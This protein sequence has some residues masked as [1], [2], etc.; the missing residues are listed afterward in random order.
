MNR[1]SVLAALVAGG[2]TLSGCTSRGAP[3]SDTNTSSPEHGNRDVSLSSVDDAPTDAPLDP[4]VEVVQSSVSI[5]RTAQLRVTVTNSTDR[6]V[7]NK[8]VHIPAFSSFITQEGPQGQKL[9]LL[10]PDEQ[11]DT[12][13]SG[14]WRADLEEWQ[15]N[16]AYTDVVT[17]VRYDAGQS[18]TTAFDVYGHPENTG[19]CLAPGDYRIENKYAIAADVDAEEADWEFYWG[20]TL[21]VDER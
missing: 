19:P 21:T 2:P 8:H 5:D 11:Y 7:W 17:D 9:L 14:C 16:H 1:R 12:V 13:G 3:G 10:Q 4:A 18:G 15:L 20:F 6:L